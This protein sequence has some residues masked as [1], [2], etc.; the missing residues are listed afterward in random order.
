VTMLKR[1]VA[2]Q[3]RRAA[4]GILYHAEEGEWWAKLTTAER[5]LFRDK[6]L[7]SVGSFYDFVLDIIKSTDTDIINNEHA[8]RLL[9]QIHS[10]THGDRKDGS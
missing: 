9:E 3:R 4:G 5:K 7:A 2:E 8:L 10:A 6:V 1:L